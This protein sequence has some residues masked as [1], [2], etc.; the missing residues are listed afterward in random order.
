M[1]LLRAGK[2]N[3]WVS[4]SQRP[5]SSPDSDGFWDPLEPEYTWAS[6]TPFAPGAELNTTQAVI[7]LRYRSDIT[8]D[9]RIVYGT[10]Q[11]FVRGIQNVDEK[12][13][14]LQLLCEEVRA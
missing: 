14:E 13:V 4:L 11:F 1:A 2:L 10:R 3:K 6:I 7:V 5:Q 9:T 12:D 8:F